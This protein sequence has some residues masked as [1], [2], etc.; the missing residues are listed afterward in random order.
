VSA[1]PLENLASSALSAPRIGL[2]RRQVILARPMLHV[3]SRARP[4]QQGRWATTER[5][6]RSHQALLLSRTSM[7]SSTQ[8]SRCN[9]CAP[10]DAQK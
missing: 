4:R 1:P 9:Y 3:G 8:R 5:S 10:Q 7:D 2:A 6:A